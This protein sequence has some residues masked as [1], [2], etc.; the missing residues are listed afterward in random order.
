MNKKLAI[1]ISIFLVLFI[2]T[3]IFYQNQ[4]DHKKE[5]DDLLGTNEVNITKI[6]MRDGS[7]GISVETTN[8]E[9]IKNFINLFNTRYYKKSLNQEDKAGYHYY[10]DLYTEDKRIIR[11][12]G[13]GDSVE[14]NNTY[15]DVSIP[16]SFDSL[17]NWFN[18]LSVK[19]A[20]SLA[21]KGESEDW[22][23]EYK[24]DAIVTATDENGL[25][26][27]T[28]NKS[29]IVTYKNDL[30]DLSKVKKWEISCEYIGGSVTQ[31][32]SRTDKDDPINSN[33]FVINCGGSTNSYS[34]EK[35][36]DVITVSINIDGSIQKFELKCK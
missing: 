12:N 4:K 15:Y 16:I 7:N 30:S 2:L 22:A 35:K 14:I 18:T 32:E 36:D 6:F 27:Y 21:F 31:S 3:I 9:R 13:E 10:Y 1:V 26:L 20:Y 28:A 8:K 34:I 11:I 25:N 29:L 5:F 17:T 23:A 19:D 33:T 24:V